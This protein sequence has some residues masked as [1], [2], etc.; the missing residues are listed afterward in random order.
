MI[1]YLGEIDTEFKKYFKLFISG[2]DVFYSLKNVKKS[3]DAATLRSNT[4]VDIRNA[5]IDANMI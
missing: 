2:P 4:R 1:E 3:H 5:N